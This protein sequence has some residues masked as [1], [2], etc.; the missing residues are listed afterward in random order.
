M[1]SLKTSGKED[2][3]GTGKNRETIIITQ[4]KPHADP[5]GLELMPLI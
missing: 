1:K 4:G 2:T 3:S 5:V